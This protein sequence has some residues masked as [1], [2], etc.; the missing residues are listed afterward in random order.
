MKNFIMNKVG[1]VFAV[2]HILIGVILT[3][4]MNAPADSFTDLLKYLYAFLYTV[5]FPVMIITMIITHTFGIGFGG[6][7][8]FI[9]LTYA[10]WFVIGCGIN[11]VVIWV[12]R[13]DQLR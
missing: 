2:A 3:F 12:L 9:V 13:E 8:M 7:I 4:H 11:A 1:H 6:L 10:Q 5:D